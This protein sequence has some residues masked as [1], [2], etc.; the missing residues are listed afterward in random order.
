MKNSIIMVFILPF[1]LVSCKD[2]N[3]TNT[4]EDEE[5]SFKNKGHEWVHA[6][7][8]KVGDYSQL[9]AKE[10][11]AYTYTYTTP[12]GKTDRSF[13][14]Y[15]FDGEL[16]YGAYINH[17]RTLPE[18]EGVIEQAYDG[19]EYWLKHQ[20]ELVSD[21]DML[22]R[23]AFNRPTNFYWF[24]MMQKLLDPGVQYEYLGKETVDEQEYALVK[25]SFSSENQPTDIYQLYINTETLLVDQFLFTVADFGK[26]EVPSLMRLEYENVEG[27]LIPSKRK[28]KASTWTAEVTNEPWIYVTWTAIEFN[29]GITKEAFKKEHTMQNKNTASLGALL[30]DRIARADM[31]PETDK[32][33]AYREG[34]A[35]VANSDILSNAKQVGDEAPDFTLNNALGTP[36]SLSDYLKEGYVIITWYRGGWCPYCNLTLLHLQNELSNFKANGASLIALTPEL[37]DKSLSTSEKNELEFEVLSDPGNKIAHEYGIVF[38]LT[39]AVSEIYNAQFDLNGYNGDTSNELPLAATYII[40]PE[41]EIVYAFLD[42]DYRKRA[43]PAE[44][45]EFLKTSP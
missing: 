17:E 22:K 1:L 31:A 25:I 10:S 6:M 2:A 4:Q 45:T 14:K 41:G 26:M 23:V 16:S 28:Y 3:Q 12:D 38:Q 20:G 32:K 42:A 21:E 19:E 36:V 35:A 5:L 13:E 30:E 11:V 7:V 40:N 29:T 34:I 43:E 18:L 33:K 9:A 8:Q 39:D 27:I 15:I 24:T 44:L 37:P